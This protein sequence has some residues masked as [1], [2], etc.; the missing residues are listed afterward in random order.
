MPLL[1]A[2]IRA[3]GKPK[4]VRY[5]FNQYLSIAP[6]EYVAQAGLLA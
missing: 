1:T 6:P 5:A 2:V 3:V 4:I